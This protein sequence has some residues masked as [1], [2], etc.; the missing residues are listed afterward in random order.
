VFDNTT[1]CGRGRWA[2]RRF[3]LQADEIKTARRNSRR[4]DAESSVIRSV[5][6]T[7][8]LCIHPVATTPRRSAAYHV[9]FSRRQH[10]RHADAQRGIAMNTASP[11][12]DAVEKRTA[13]IVVTVCRVRLRSGYVVTTH[14]CGTGATKKKN[15]SGSRR[16][17]V[18]CDNARVS[19]QV[20]LIKRAGDKKKKKQGNLWNGQ[21]KE[22]I[23][24]KRISRRL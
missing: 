18:R 9:A 19:G 11:R 22:T 6:N 23:R 16:P 20:D 21:G 14:M 4:R 2:G 13:V 3:A 5:A 17:N 7:V 15:R 10:Y 12:P 8:R 1:N 24:A